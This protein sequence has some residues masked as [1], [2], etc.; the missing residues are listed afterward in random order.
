MSDETLY[1]HNRPPLDDPA[2]VDVDLLRARLVEKTA[3]AKARLDELVDGLGKVPEIIDNEPE[4]RRAISFLAQC[5]I[6]FDTWEELRKA[7][8][9]PVLALGQAVQDHFLPL[10]TGALDFM[11]RV[12][13]RLA[14]FNAKHNAKGN[15]RGLYGGSMVPGTDWTIGVENIR[16]VPYAYLALDTAAVKRAIKAG[17]TSIPGLKIE[18]KHTVTVRK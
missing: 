11:E 1:G 15:M 8:R 10:A 9:A 4:A 14:V 3:E 5:S 12:T 18:D 7:E 13:D 17:V 6:A 16:D 2:A